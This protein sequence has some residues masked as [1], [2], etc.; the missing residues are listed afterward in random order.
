MSFK[1]K[2]G[3]VGLPGMD[4]RPGPKGEKGMNGSPGLFGLPGL[5]GERGDYGLAGHPGLSGFPGL[6]VNLFQ[7]I[8]ENEK[9][10]GLH[11]CFRARKVI[12]VTF[13][14]SLNE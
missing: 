7:N 4:G 14:V 3:D 12:P 8:E 5:K 9:S 6:K 2:Q 10:S 1:G 11:S 13:L